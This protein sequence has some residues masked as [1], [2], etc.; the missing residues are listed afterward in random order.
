MRK[1]DEWN[2]LMQDIIE[3]PQNSANHMVFGMNKDQRNK[4][5]GIDSGKPVPTWI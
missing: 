3:N 2:S 5:K 1:R 4:A